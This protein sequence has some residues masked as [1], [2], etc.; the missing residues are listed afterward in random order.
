[1]KRSAE[2]LLALTK[3]KDEGHGDKLSQS[4]QAY[5]NTEDGI[6]IKNDRLLVGCLTA[7]LLKFSLLSNYAGAL[8]SRVTHTNMFYVERQQGLLPM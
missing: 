3:L 5:N 4:S 1:M 2:L 6:K 8:S 7:C